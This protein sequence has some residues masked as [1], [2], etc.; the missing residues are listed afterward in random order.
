[1]DYKAVKSAF[2]EQINYSIIKFLKEKIMQKDN[3]TEKSGVSEG[4]ETVFALSGPARFFKN[5]LDC[6]G[7]GLEEGSILLGGSSDGGMFA[8]DFL[9]GEKDISDHMGL[10]DRIVDLYSISKALSSLFRDE[11]VEN[12]W[13]RESDERLDGRSPMELMLDGS[14]E[15]FLKIKELVEHMSSPDYI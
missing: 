6:W 10:E 3:H 4:A 2:V 8:E 13:L 12:Q 14:G 1:M 7:L 5:L 9:C 11:A 15:S